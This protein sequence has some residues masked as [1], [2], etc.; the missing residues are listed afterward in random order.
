MA[1][2]AGEAL[3]SYLGQQLA[4]LRRYA[5]GVRE[6]QA[7]SI[8]EM[9]VAA[10]RIRSLLATTR[11]LFA[12][13]DAEDVRS[14]LRWLSGA[15]GAARDPGVVQ[16][17]LRELLASEPEEL[18]SG[19]AAQR[20]D[21]ELDAAAAAGHQGAL[22]ALGSERYDRL[23]LSLGTLL[24]AD[25]LSQKASRPPQ[26]TLRKFVARETAR[27]ARAVADLPP[28][29]Q[30][31]AR[32][33]ELHEV[34]KAAKRLRYSAELAVTVGGRRAGKRIR[35]AAKAAR[36]IQTTLGL[37]HDSVVART[38]LAELGLRSLP[39]G[40][41]GFSYGRLHAREESLA[42]SSEAEFLKI[43]KDFRG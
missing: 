19:Q 7:E 17:R 29:S 5:P 1:T 13:G 23:L 8:H 3:L 11:K 28:A 10:R 27:L 4:E 21:A 42:A 41:N 9:R 35:K 25:R 26:R 22:E 24:A 43:W 34:R 36:R 33:A 15:L 37:H 6:N 16:A 32:D 30:G 20:I 14:E 31:R 38:L 2:T 39:S 18:T 12:A 40:E